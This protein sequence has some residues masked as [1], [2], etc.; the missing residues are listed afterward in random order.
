MSKIKE[1]TFEAEGVDPVNFN[2]SWAATK[3]KEQFVAEFDKVYYQELPAAKREAL[4]A[5]AYETCL[6][7]TE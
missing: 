3:T 7:A 6:A 1:I 4:L 5:Q 2:A